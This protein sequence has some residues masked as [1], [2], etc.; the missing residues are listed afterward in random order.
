[1]SESA[2]CLHAGA[3][4][5]T[6]DELRAV[7]TPE[8][9]KTWFP[10]AHV[11]VIDA[12]GQS[13]RN[14]GFT[15]E[16]AKYGL[17]RND[18]RLFATLDLFT[19]LA[20]GVRLAVG[21]RN[22]L[23]KSLPLGFCAGSRVF[24][25]DNLAFRSELLVT[26]RHTK[27]GEVRFGE[28]IANAVQSLEQF[29]VVERKRILRLGDTSINDER[30]ESTIL[31]AFDQGIVSHLLLPKV[32][33]EWRTPSFE[34]FQPRTLWS[35]FNAFTTVLSPRVKSNPQQ[36]AALTMRLNGLFDSPEDANGM[37]A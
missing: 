8:A 28:A 18:G 20:H 12:V 27:H 26:R 10:V 3:R 32:I 15:V 19:N 17:S 36:F 35:L 21:V 4:E 23:D 9:T 25:C 34:D 6:I 1:M 11:S 7:K 30:A 14:A 37:A 31:K 24:V 2:L 22:S 13:L 5:V 29:Q 33:K 16:K